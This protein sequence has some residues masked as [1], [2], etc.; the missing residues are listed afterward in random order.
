MGKI[1]VILYLTKTFKMLQY[2]HVTNKNIFDQVFYTF[3][4]LKLLF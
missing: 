2:Q 3:S 1:T 4:Y